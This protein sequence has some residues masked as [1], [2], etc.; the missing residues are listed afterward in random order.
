MLNPLSSLFSRRRKPVIF[1]LRIE[2][3]ITPPGGHRNS[4]TGGHPKLP[5]PEPGVDIPDWDVRRRDVRLLPSH[6]EGG[7][8]ERFEASSADHD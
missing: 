2:R 3:L 6:Q 4:P 1:D 5:H 7:R 8:S